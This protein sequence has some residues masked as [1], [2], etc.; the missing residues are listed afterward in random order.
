MSLI[1]YRDAVLFQVKPSSFSN[2]S[3]A[4]RGRYIQGKVESMNVRI[5][6]G[7]SGT[8][9]RVESVKESD[10]RPTTM[11]RLI[12]GARSKDTLLGVYLEA[13]EPPKVRL[14]KIPLNPK[15][16]QYPPSSI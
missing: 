7:K 6:L 14:P 12:S 5:A 15:V 11:S 16:I 1:K 10:R 8:A 3:H 9:S 13:S 2:A 4:S